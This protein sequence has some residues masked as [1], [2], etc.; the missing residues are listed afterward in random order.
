MPKDAG[1]A[2]MEIFAKLRRGT[3]RDLLS[4][5]SKSARASIF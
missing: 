1:R 2:G 5:G 4:I 3:G